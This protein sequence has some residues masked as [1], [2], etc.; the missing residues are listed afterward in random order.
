MNIR[1]ENIDDLN[2]VLSI[3]LQ[4]EDY[5]VKVGEVLNDYRKKARIDGF[6]PGKVPFGMISKMYRKPVLV[7]EVNKLVSESIS[8]YLVDEKLHILGEPIP[9][10]GESKAIDWDNDAAFEFKFDLGIAPEF[11]LKISSKDKIPHYTIKADKSVIDKY[12]ESYTQRFGEFVTVD[13]IAEKDMIKA[14]IKEYNESGNNDHEVVAANDVTISVDLIRDEKIKKKVLAA[15]KGD[16]LIID[17]KKAYPGEVELAALLK[18]SKEELAGTGNDFSVSIKEITRFENAPVNQELFDKVFG[19]GVIAS[20]QEFLDRITEEAKKGLAEDSDYRLRIDIKDMLMKKFKGDLPKE[21]LKRWLLMINEGKFDMEQIEK[22]FDH[23][24]EDLK[25]QLIKDKIVT[26]NGLKIED[27]D[28][29][30]TA[31]DIARMQFA[32]YGMNNIPDEHLIE[33]ARRM[34]EKEDE[35]NN[36]YGQVVERKV[37]ETVRGVIKL[38]EKEIT[39]EKF[40]KL[41]EK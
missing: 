33:F 29:H 36:I 32:Q 39:S 6:R 14:D 11:D 31:I 25:W 7:E 16:T 9:H 13:V 41:F 34:L 12:I 37:I 24:E 21:F 20:E 4:K 15:K 30:R 27:E 22:E 10:A 35:K 18:I 1:K 26:D 2:A 5:E 38:D 8:K 3:T 23:F 40:S 19:E 28:M 17:L